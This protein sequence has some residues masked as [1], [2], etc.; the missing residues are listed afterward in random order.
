MLKGGIWKETPLKDKE[1]AANGTETACRGR[2]GTEKVFET[3]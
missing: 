3:I 2:A 1:E